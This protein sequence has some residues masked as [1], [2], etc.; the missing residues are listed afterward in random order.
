MEVSLVPLFSSSRIAIGFR[1]FMRA[2]ISFEE[3]P[4][5]N[6]STQQ[7]MQLA[8]EASSVNGMINLRR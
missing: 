5:F 6:I 1:A 8:I 7:C 4:I 2:T 3:I